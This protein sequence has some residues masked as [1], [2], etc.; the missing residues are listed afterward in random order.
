MTNII[1]LLSPPFAK[2]GN[3]SIVEKEQNPQTCDKFQDLQTNCAVWLSSF[4]LYS[5]S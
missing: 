4:S 2:I 3:R 5:Q 1:T